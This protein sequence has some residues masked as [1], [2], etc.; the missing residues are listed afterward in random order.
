MTKRPLPIADPNGLFG[1]AEGIRQKIPVFD[2]PPP[3]TVELVREFRDALE[4][5]HLSTRDSVIRWA[6]GKG[7][8]RPDIVLAYSIA[9][10]DRLNQLKREGIPGPRVKAWAERWKLT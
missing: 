1:D 6:A 4:K 7:V 3:T 9:F 2:G 5:R 10:M 8:Q